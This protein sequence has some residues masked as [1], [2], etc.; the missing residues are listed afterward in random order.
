MLRLQQRHQPDQFVKLAYS[1]VTLGRDDSNSFVI[2]G[3]SVSDFHAE[4]ICD[5]HRYYLVDL[6][7]ANGTFI[8]KQRVSVRCELKPWDVLRL[9]SVELEVID[10]NSYRPGAWALRPHESQIVSPFYLI[11]AK[12][13]VGRD[14][15]CDITIDS[16]MLSRH[17]TEL[18]IEGDRLRVK[19]LGSKNGTFVNGDQVTIAIAL[20][21]DELRFDQQS[22]IVVGPSGLQIK[23]S[24]DNGNS[25]VIR[26]ALAY[27]EVTVEEAQANVALGESDDN[28]LLERQASPLAD[29]DMP[30]FRTP[31]TASHGVDETRFMPLESDSEA[32][33]FLGDGPAKVAASLAI[34]PP[35]RLLASLVEK[36]NLLRHRNLSL[37]DDEYLMGRGESNTVV[38]S[39]ASI[40]KRHA[41]LIYENGHWTIN[42][43]HSR[44]GTF[45]NALVITEAQLQNGDRIA[46]GKAEF[47]FECEA[48]E[49][50]KTKWQA[51]VPR[52]KFAI[53]L[54][55]YGVGVVGIAAL[56]A[57]L[58][59]LWR[60]GLVFF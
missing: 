10:P 46:L 8:N 38:L 35:P 47:I 49:R 12:T 3:V 9:G 1:S 13:V 2:D 56:A 23:E 39:D 36:S 17:H 24:L 51:S 11:N 41:R 21:G 44:N 52:R 57:V 59:Y 7:S 37:A 58:L 20:P 32:T 50:L 14:P 31:N 5:A 6:L 25:T 19:D 33:Q 43:L 30:V 34:M 60:R 48:T 54:W 40:S 22:F 15:D 27:S 53:P 18:S 26:S 55:C 28:I 16:T 29:I 45:V 42:D 4:I